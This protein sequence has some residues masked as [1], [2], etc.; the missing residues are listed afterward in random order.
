MKRT[1]KLFGI[2]VWT[3]ESDL[4]LEVEDETQEP[5]SMAS[6]NTI[7]STTTPVF[8][9]VTPFEWEEYE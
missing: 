9:F 6:D 4:E 8:G 5:Y 3:I 7:S 1:Y 2:P